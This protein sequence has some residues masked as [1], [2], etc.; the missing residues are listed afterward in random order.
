MIEI[1]KDLNS[2]TDVH[3]ILV[4]LPL[5]T[6]LNEQKILDEISPAKDVDGFHPLNVGSKKI[7]ALLIFSVVLA[8]KGR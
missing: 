5:P 6:Y 4:Q 2:R 8:L 7:N 3:G 1:I